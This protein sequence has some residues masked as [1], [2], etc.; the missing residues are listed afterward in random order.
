MWNDGSREISRVV[1]FLCVK[2]C[3]GEGE[4]GIL[5]FVA[6]GLILPYFLRERPE[7]LLRPS[8]YRA[9]VTRW[10]SI[11]YI[12]AVEGKKAFNYGEKSQIQ[13]VALIKFAYDKAVWKIDHF[14]AI[15]FTAGLSVIFHDM[16]SSP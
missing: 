5:L 8:S 10:R 4:S 12:C 1:R 6:V 9:S 7:F 16:D 13:S 11:F 3:L 14:E 15:S 2:L